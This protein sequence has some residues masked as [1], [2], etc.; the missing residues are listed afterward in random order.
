[1]GFCWEDAGRRIVSRS[2]R[3][4]AATL[5]P[6]L[7]LLLGCN[8]GGVCRTDSSAT[9][10]ASER[11][12]GD[13]NLDL[14]AAANWAS[15]PAVKYRSEQTRGAEAEAKKIGYEHA[16]GTVVKVSRA[17]VT[18]VTVR[19]G[20]SISFDIEY[21]LLSPEKQLDVSEEWEIVRDGK[22]IT[23]TFPQIKSRR[24]GGWRAQASIDLPRGIKPGSYVLRSR[25]RSGKLADERD[26]PFT[27]ARVAQAKRTEEGKSAGATAVDRDLM[28]V[29]GQLKELGHDPGAIDGLMS[30]QTQAALKAFQKDYGLETTGQVDAE[31][32]AALG[33]GTQATP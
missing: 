10:L 22:R 19:P 14:A 7:A 27:V 30:P 26:S 31:T 18:P 28:Q 2:N 1:M 24:P 5:A 4:A 11:R 8:A 6:I 33:L 17:S 15:V 20:K 29:Q 32:R 16:Q 21:A 25:V 3:S 13:A 9:Q 23:S 12:T